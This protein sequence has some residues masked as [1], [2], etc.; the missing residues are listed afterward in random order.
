M[1]ERLKYRVWCKNKKEY[2]KDE[3]FLTEDGRLFQLGAYGNMPPLS[4][5]THIVEQ[6]TGTSINNNE[7]VFEGDIIERTYI[8]PMTSKEVKTV[9]HVEWTNTGFMLNDTTNKCMSVSLREFDKSIM[10]YK[11]TGNIHNKESDEE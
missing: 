4:L 2:E 5:D 7:L 10:N 3:C 6:C 8:N 11:I 1:N 9:Y